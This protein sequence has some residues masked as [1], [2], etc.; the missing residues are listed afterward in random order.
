[1]IGNFENIK[2]NLN[3]PEW[4]TNKA[5]YSRFAG[6]FL[7]LYDF[8]FNT[9]TDFL[10]ENNWRNAISSEFLF[11]IH[12]AKEN[13][14]Q[15][16]ETLYY[17]SQQ[18]FQYKIY[19]GKIRFVLRFN[20][21][22]EFHQLLSIYSGQYFKGFLYDKNNNLYG[23]IDSTQI[24][25]FDLDFIDLKKII[26]GNS[27]TPAWSELYLEF[28]D[29]QELLNAVIEKPDWIISKVKNVP[30]LISDITAPSSDVIKFLVTDT[31]CEIPIEGLLEADFTILDNTYG[32]ISFDSFTELG[33]GY[34]QIDG[35]NDYTN[36][37]INIDTL[38]YNASQEYNLGLIDVTIQSFSTTDQYDITFD[39]IITA[40]SN[41]VTDIVSEDIEINDTIS[42]IVPIVGFTNNGSGNY[43]LETSLILTNG[44]L[45]II[46]TAYSGSD[47]YNVG[48]AKTNVTISSITSSDILEI[49]FYVETTIGGTPVAGLLTGDIEIN[50]SLNGILLHDTFTDYGNG[51]YKIV[52]NKAV[53]GGTITINNATYTGTENYSFRNM[54]VVYTE[55]MESFAGSGD[56]QYP[57]GWTLT[58]NNS[59]G[60][61]NS[62]QQTGGT[63]IHQVLQLSVVNYQRL[64]SPQELTVDELFYISFRYKT[65]HS[66]DPSY[67]Y[68]TLGG[69]KIGSSQS[70]GFW[71]EDS[72][73]YKTI[74]IPF[75]VSSTG[76]Y[77]Y[78]EL[79]E[80][81][82][83]SAYDIDITIDEIIIYQLL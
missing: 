15:S 10:I 28:S 71:L 39:V 68:F 32:S 33:E 53:T 29:A 67:Y 61:N 22:I 27:Q 11:P 82:G 5:T 66:I 52:V 38:Y 4:V 34:Y 50:D 42:G 65:N 23:V 58:S 56:Q 31:Y 3:L 20:Y 51:N 48:T 77:F 13:E 25:G 14:N 70:T 55:N 60:A 43:T 8:K 78:Y 37:T 21:N 19:D 74:V 9:L 79:L 62:V 69:I 59:F 76:L 17:T 44:T 2:L 24:K 18:D 81:A 49:E 30:L 63:A 54:V 40:N 26:L 6:I 73:D 35:D 1:M 64:V 41:P 12:E 7:S 47:T 72:V 83:A 45:T 36:G 46:N 75:G 16:E 80:L 57:S